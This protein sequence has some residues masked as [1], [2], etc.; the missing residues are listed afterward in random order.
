MTSRT[1][2]PFYFTGFYWHPKV[3]IHFYSWELLWRFS[4]IGS[5]PWIVLSDFNEILNLRE[6]LG[7]RIWPQQEMEKNF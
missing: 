5:L 3:A 6:K 7:G 1:K 2:L 4:Q